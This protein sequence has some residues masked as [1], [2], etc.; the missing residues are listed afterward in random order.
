MRAAIY[1]RVSTVRQAE[2]DLSIPDQRRVCQEYC[3]KNGWTVVTEYLEPGKSARDDQRPEFQRM[4]SDAAASDRHFDMIVVHSFSR[5]FRDE[6]VSETYI[7]QLNKQ[8]V[9]VW[10]A[11]ENWGEGSTGELARRVVGIIAEFDNRQRIDRVVQTMAEN[12]RQGYWNGGPAPYGYR[13]KTVEMRGATAKKKLEPD[14][15]EAEIVRT[16]YRLCLHGD[17]QGPLG[18][19]AVVSHLNAQGLRY[20]KGRPFR[21]NEV[22]RVLTHSTYMGVH[23]YNRK[24]GKTGKLRHPDEWIAMEVPAIIDGETWEAVQKHLKTRRPT[25]TAPR[26]TNGAML[27]TQ[28]AKCPNCGGGM[29][30]RTGKSG[31]YRYY[32]CSTAATKGKR[33]CQGRSI[34]MEQLDDLVVAALEQRLLK[35]ERL[36]EVL[37]GLAQR[38]KERQANSLESESELAKEMRAVEKKIG[39]L[40]EAIED[41]LVDDDD[42]FRQRLSAQKQRRDELIRLKA[43][44]QRRRELP[45]KLLS[46]ENLEAFAHALR[47]RLETP[48]DKLRQAYVRMLVDS[49][50]VGEETLE[51]KGSE[52][53]LLSAVGQAD[54]FFSGEVPSSVPEWRR[55]RDSNPRYGVTVHALSRRAPSTARPPLRA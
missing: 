10:S 32:T 17:G 3:E 20:R 30:L 29:T 5:F 36:R 49:V 34:P 22:H 8:G 42:L 11:T 15:Q 6:V 41:G 55:G 51:I 16:I 54:S 4:I 9:E 37:S 46:D 50:T 33:A 25:V 12:A 48:H 7:R 24:D 19:K 1:L 2:K 21:T 44:S 18:V 47:A 31:R 52:T 27:L 53:A 40:M 28:I 26:L 14:P 13:L 45:H 38:I 35:P 23:Y 43:Q 39:R